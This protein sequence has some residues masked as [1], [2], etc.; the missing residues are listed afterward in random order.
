M[1]FRGIVHLNGKTATGIEVPGDVVAE[2]GRGRKRVPVAVT[3]G[4]HSYR[5]TIAPMSG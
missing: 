2:V 1:K 5:T 3:I 4:P